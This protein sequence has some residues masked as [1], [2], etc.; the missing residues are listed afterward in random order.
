MTLRIIIPALLLSLCVSAVFSQQSVFLPEDHPQLQHKQHEL[1]FFK[2]QQYLPNNS[3]SWIHNQHS[4]FPSHPSSYCPIIPGSLP[5]FRRMHCTQEELDHFGLQADDCLAV[6][7][8]ISPDLASG[9]ADS[10]QS[11]LSYQQ[12]MINASWLHK[13]E[14][15]E[16]I[17]KQLRREEWDFSG[18]IEGA[19][20][21]PP[22]F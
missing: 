15:I 22:G 10:Q 12:P 6:K 7:Y 16:G 14:L 1:V 5:G 4:L 2:S 19:F 21:R 18:V 13:N 11:L 3:Y 17:Q 8:G 20:M 9:V